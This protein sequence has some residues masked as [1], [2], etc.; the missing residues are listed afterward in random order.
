MKC[1]GLTHCVSMT[2]VGIF[3]QRSVALQQGIELIDQPMQLD[4]VI[5][6]NH[7]SDNQITASDFWLRK[8]HM[9]YSTGTVWRFNANKGR[10]E[11]SMALKS[12]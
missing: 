8:V 1:P 12:N 3:N 4:N 6:L 11:S 7:E 10:G 9:Q 5:S 2:T